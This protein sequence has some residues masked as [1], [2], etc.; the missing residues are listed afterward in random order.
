LTGI[1]P[2]TRAA[3]RPVA[4]VL[5]GNQRSALATVRALGRSGITVMV[6]EAQPR[7][8]AAASRY[9]RASLVYPDPSAAPE[10]FSYWL[11]QLERQHPGAVIMPMTDIT[12]PLVLRS[13]QRTPSLRS[14]LPSLAAYEAASDKFELFKLARSV[15][16]QVPQTSIISRANASQLDGDGLR[17]PV[18]VKP[19]LSALRLASGVVK[20]PVRYA[21]NAAE[22]AHLIR[23]QLLDDADE[24]LVQEH[25]SGHGA[26]IFAMYDHGTPLFFFA[27]RRIREK[28]PSGGVSVLCESVPLSPQS[29]TIARNLLEALQWHGVAMVELKVDAAGR[30]WLIEVNARF[31]GSLQ[32][33]VDCG[34]QF[35]EYVYRLAAGLPLE[36]ASGYAVGRRL[37]WW[38]GDLDNL[39]LSLKSREHTPTAWDKLKA[40]GRFA[41][42]WQPGLRYEFARLGDP[43]PAALALR[44]Y[45]GQIFGRG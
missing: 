22:L 14:A 19:R 4:I 6:A 9:C 23:S 41:L 7:S 12:V 38:L 17:F 10:A 34:A 36:V 29:M 21:Q 24:L 16:V 5:D 2:H 45:V 35:P 20:R 40:L 30:P 15:G 1:P 28:P 31:W 8:L 25:V 33:A 18:V 13:G 44:Q 37:R 27:H 26:G 32:L 11:E 43:A 42:P 3:I 39:Y